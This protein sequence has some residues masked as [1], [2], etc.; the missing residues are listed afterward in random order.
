MITGTL[1]FFSAAKGFGFIT[2]DGDGKDVFLPAATIA[3]CG[4]PK[5]QAG[6]RVSF[7]Q[8]PDA[9]GPKAVNLKLLDEKPR[10]VAPPPPAPTPAPVPRNAAMVVYC[11]M[12]TDEAADVLAALESAG[13]QPRVMDYAVTPPERDDLKR[14]SLILREADQSLVR[15]YDALFLDL[16]LDDRF[17]AESEFWTAIVEHPSLIN[18]PIVTEGA[19]A[20]ICKSAADVR[21]FLGVSGPAEAKKAPKEISPRMAEMMK[22][23]AVPSAPLR[24]P[25]PLAAPESRSDA[26]VAEAPAKPVQRILV[27]VRPRPHSLIPAAPQPEAAPAPQPV[28]VEPPKAAKPAA[29]VKKAAKPAPKPVAK[30]AV[31]KAPAKKAKPVAVKKKKK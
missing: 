1:K 6:Q 9:K 8:E 30:K 29:T 22:A 27:P 13:R 7:E 21:A 14:L 19:K 10:P 2:P 28:I 16:Q 5:L 11:D 4:A 24:M 23:L 15:R 31:A 18:G 17:I 20:G 26:A 12:G 25:G 3:A